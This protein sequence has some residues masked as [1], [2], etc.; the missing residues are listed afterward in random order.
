MV[1]IRTAVIALALVLF[2]LAS[3]HATEDGTRVALRGYDPL[4]YFEEGKPEKGS[5]QYTATYEGVVY[6]FKSEAHKQAF[7][8]KPDKYAPQFNGFCAID[9]SRGLKTEPDPEAFTI[10]DGKLYVFGKKRGPGVF[11]QEG[12]AI[13][14]KATENWQDLRNK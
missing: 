8:A 13:V 11:A 6:W 3:L 14:A 1:S 12:S 2:S 9:L 10:A 7:L 4:N 5:D